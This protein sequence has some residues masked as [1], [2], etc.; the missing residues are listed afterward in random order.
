MAGAELLCHNF[1]W[2]REMAKVGNHCSIGFESTG[3]GFN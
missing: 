1:E 3:P 2:G